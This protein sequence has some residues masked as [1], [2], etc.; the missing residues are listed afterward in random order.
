MVAVGAAALPGIGGVDAG[1]ARRCPA[2]ARG[3]KLGALAAGR[4]LRRGR[5]RRKDQ[6]KPALRSMNV[7]SANVATTWNARGHIGA[8]CRA[9][10]AMACPRLRVLARK[11]TARNGADDARRDAGSSKAQQS[12]QSG[13]WAVGLHVLLQVAAAGSPLAP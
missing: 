8:C 3:S 12:A 10:L 5:C 6:A 13:V 2:L 1:L 11:N 4:R 9:L 7:D